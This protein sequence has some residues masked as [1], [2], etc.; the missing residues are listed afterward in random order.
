MTGVTTCARWIRVIAVATAALI[1]ASCRSLSVPVAT[2]GTAVV[3]LVI[4]KNKFHP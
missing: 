2:L 4:I 1:L 3:I